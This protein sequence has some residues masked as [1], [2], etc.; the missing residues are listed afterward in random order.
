MFQIQLP[1]QNKNKVI[2]CTMPTN[3][4]DALQ[5]SYQDRLHEEFGQRNTGI[6]L[7][8]LISSCKDQPTRARACLK[9]LTLLAAGMLCMAS[10]FIIQPLSHY[11][12]AFFHPCDNC[13]TNQLLVARQQERLLHN[14]LVNPSEELIGRY[15]LA[16][17]NGSG[18]VGIHV[19]LQVGT[20]KV[21]FI[22]RYD[23]QGT[24]ARFQDGRTAWST[25]YDYTIDAFRP[26]RLVS[27]VFCGAGKHT[28]SL[29]RFKLHCLSQRYWSH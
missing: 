11:S 23:Y 26:L 25:E 16:P 19:A 1:T 14:T 6:H 27:N 5:A 28:K 24:Q 18:V 13:Q 10:I 9:S 15:V 17:G 22:E 3:R 21:V 4:R 20:G 12:K 29:S 8:T 2:D 7:V